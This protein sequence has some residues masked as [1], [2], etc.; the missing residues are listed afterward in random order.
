MDRKV[1]HEVAKRG[2]WSLRGRGTDER[3]GWGR[4]TGNWSK[5]IKPGEK[6]MRTKE[7]ERRT[8]KN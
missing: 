1:E 3:K 6:V 7:D 2:K 5:A 8:K 4:K